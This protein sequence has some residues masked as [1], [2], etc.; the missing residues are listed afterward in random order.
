MSRDI[1]GY[2]TGTAGEVY[3]RARAVP[4]DVAVVGGAAAVAL[5]LGA[6]NLAAPSLWHDELVHVFVAQSI[7]E[8]GRAVL[9]S[10]EPYYNGTVFNALLAGV[11]KVWGTGEAAVRAP[12]VVFGA[13]N[14][15]L[16]FLV[17]RPL[18]GRNT[19]V[20]AAVGLAVSPWAVAWSREARFYALQQ[21]LYLA[22]MGAFWQLTIGRN[23]K[24]MWTWGLA[25]LTAYG[26]AVLTSYHSVLFLAAPGAYVAGLWISDRRWKSRWLALGAGIGLAG[27]A[28]LLGMGAL[29]NSVDRQAVVSNSGLGGKA[30]DAAR[31]YRLYYTHWLRMNLSTGFF[32]AALFGF[33]ALVVREGRRGA[34]AALAFWAPIL[35]LTFAIGY[36]R[37]RFMFFAYPFYVAAWAYGLV[38]ATE[39]LRKPKRDVVRRIAAVGLVLFLARLSYSAVELIGDS[40]NAA[41]GADTTLARRH[42][43]WR[44]PCAWVREHAGNG[45]VVTTTYLPV[46]FYVGRVDSWYPSRG[47]PHE[48]K[49]SGLAGLAD[50]AALK[51]FVAEHPNGVF[52]AE[53]WRFE[54]NYAGAPWGD[55]SD[56]IA[57]V[58]ANMTRVEEASSEDVTVYTW[59]GAGQGD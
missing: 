54:R 37:P 2:A 17:L 4:W 18:L 12:S 52:L 59:G 9:P 25:A 58:Q 6:L 29:M 36:R 11:I 41:S 39:W 30:V 56:D 5:V 1:R 47:L 26:L 34:F 38:V 49:E 32:V 16:T 7:A 44:G 35:V 15:V 21:T 45:A 8:T 10:G 48:S 33:A 3:S 22:C 42:P 55:F 27:I 20:V 24:A 43:Q 50:V 51:A 40:V 53:W 28:G 57:W 19:A 46:R 23:R 14:V 13:V 31:S